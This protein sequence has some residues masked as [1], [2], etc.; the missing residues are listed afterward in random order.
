MTRPPSTLIGRENSVA[1]ATAMLR[2]PEV[3]LLTISGPGGVGKTRLAHAVA[4]AAEDEFADGIVFVA[5]QAVLDPGHVVGTI[6]RSLGLFDGEGDLEER[7][8]AHLG[9]RALLLVVDNFE[10]VTEAAPSVAAIIAQSPRLKVVV[11]SRA[12][13]RVSGEHELPLEPLALADAVTVFM[14]RAREVRPDFQPDAA[15]SEAIADICDQLDCLPLAIELAAA[16][17]KVLSPRAML[18][19]L[20]RPLELLT[21]GPQDAPARHRALRDTIGW[22]VE[23][24]DDVERALFRRL[25]AFA[26]GCTLEAAE[27]VCGATLDTLGSLVD[28]SLVLASGDRFGMLETIREYATEQLAD[29]DDADA[30]RHAHAAY[31][32]E[33]A[34]DARASSQ[35]EG[36]AVLQ[37]EHDNLRAVLRFSLEAGD[38]ATALRLGAVLS[39]FW[40]ERGYLSEGRLWLDRSLAA[41]AEGSIE[42]AA[43]LSGNGVLAHYQGDYDRAAALSLDALELAR[44]LGDVRG[45]AE[46]YTGLAL[47]PRT[48][49]D[50][51]E[52]ERLFREALAVYEELGEDAGVARTLDRLA[53]ML[54]ITGDDARARP[55]FERSLALFR[56]LGDV[57]GIALG[58]YGLGVARPD[59]GLVAAQA[60]SDESLDILRTLG[61]RR[62]FGKVLWNVAEINTELAQAETAA[63]QFAESLTLFVEFGDRW[64]CGLV[65][66]SSAFLAGGIGEDERA[67]TLLGAAEA[68]WTRLEVPRMAR[69]HERHESTLARARARLGERRLEAAW[70]EGRRLPLAA[71][72][73]LVAAIGARATGDAPDGLTARELE[74]LALVAEGRTDAEVA[75]SLVVSLRTV[76]AHLRS[77]Y[78]KLDLHTRSAATRY[79]LEHGLAT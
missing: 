70:A 38:I 20:E 4:S 12:R 73:E 77:I 58:L 42:R 26:G 64:F 3:Q 55:L 44:S 10:Q 8:I 37:I 16:R 31:F 7:L 67:V 14:E 68:I 74:V 28:K 66:E 24:L 27:K 33:I 46:A 19:R 13:L 25:S 71:T 35:T 76:H 36:W 72:V 34:R 59:G 63:A 18:A 57:H 17:A 22:S 48:R 65:L 11:T 41:S 6:A 47:V 9:D 21:A 51:A 23:L 2:R 49:G 75:E 78:R 39:H 40:F 60:E 43:A 1:A 54:V 56:R 29:D 5:L 30:V 61:D 50:Y 53:M 69:L 45:I 52:A 15:E 62:T 79:A 32:L